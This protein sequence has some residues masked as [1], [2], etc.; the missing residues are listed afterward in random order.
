MLEREI[1]S[2]LVTAFVV[3]VRT[4]LCAGLIRKRGLVLVVLD[5]DSATGPPMT[6]IPYK[7]QQQP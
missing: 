7:Y 4:P 6:P 3:S 5:A 2:G 1:G